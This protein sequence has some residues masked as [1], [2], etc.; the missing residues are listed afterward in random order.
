VQRRRLVPLLLL[1]ALLLPVR[2]L[3]L[4]Q[5]QQARGRLPV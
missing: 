5:L 3:A 1:P 4:E 2:L